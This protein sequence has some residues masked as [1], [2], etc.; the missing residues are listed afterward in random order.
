MKKKDL[1]EIKQQLLDE[2]TN[3]ETELAKFAKQ[4]PKNPEDYQA[5][6]EDI[7]D[8]ET[9]N[10]SEVAKYGLNLTLEKTLEKS[11]RD[12]NKTL[13]RIEKGDYGKCKY[14][15]QDINVKRLKARPTSGACIHCKTKL[16]S[17]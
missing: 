14:C 12:V 7:G 4:N 11:L 13:D 5:Q 3:L 10:T 1:N 17:L 9:E 16:K 15:E 2:K 8:D 6:F